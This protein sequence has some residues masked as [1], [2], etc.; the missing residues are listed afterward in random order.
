MIFPADNFLSQSL[1]KQDQNALRKLIVP[2]QLIDFCSNDYLGFAQSLELKND[3][4][5]EYT[6]LVSFVS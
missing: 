4:E 5:E 6:S 2:N 1:Q 3:I